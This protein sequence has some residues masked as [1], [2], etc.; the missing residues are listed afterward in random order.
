ML[1]SNDND[2]CVAPALAEA[3]DGSKLETGAEGGRRVVVVVVEGKAA[4]GVGAE[5]GSEGAGP[6]DALLLLGRPVATGRFLVVVVMMSGT[7]VLPNNQTV[8]SHGE[9]LVGL[10]VLSSRRSCL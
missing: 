4:R 6:R 9:C 8:R 7:G 2:A 3:I 10:G 1:G 5:A